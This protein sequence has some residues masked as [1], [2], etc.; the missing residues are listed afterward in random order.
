MREI[1]A[2]LVQRGGG[3]MKRAR[4]PSWIGRRFERKGGR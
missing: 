4:L 3:L 2:Y 1:N